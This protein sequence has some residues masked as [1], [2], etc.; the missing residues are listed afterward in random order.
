MTPDTLIEMLRSAIVMAAVIVLPV[1]GVTF[2]VSVVVSILQALTSLQDSTISTVPRLV[3]AAAAAAVTA[4]W[5][6]HKVIAYSVAVIQ[7]IGRIGR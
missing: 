3:V 2:V 7:S 1:I 4:P 6:S 5:V